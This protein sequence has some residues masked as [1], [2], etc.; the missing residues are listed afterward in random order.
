MYQ[1][2]YLPTYNLKIWNS[3]VMKCE[4]FKS[5]NTKEVT[6]IGQRKKWKSGLITQFQW[7]LHAFLER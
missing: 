5:L 6:K 2:I 7:N 3:T 4:I 1:F